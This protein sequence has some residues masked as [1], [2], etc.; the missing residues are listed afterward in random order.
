MYAQIGY[1]SKN[2]YLNSS[3]LKYCLCLV[4]ASSLP[5]HNPENPVCTT[6]PTHTH[7]LKN[8][9]QGMAPKA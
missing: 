9:E 4:G 6:P 8:S 1:I 3:K 5:L 7:T 2:Y